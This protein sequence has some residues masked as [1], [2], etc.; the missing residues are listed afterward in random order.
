MNENLKTMNPI[1]SVIS[2]TL[3]IFDKIIQWK[4][5]TNNA[6]AQMRILFIECKKTMHY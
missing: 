1:T 2:P 3:S 5:A 4:N 6:E